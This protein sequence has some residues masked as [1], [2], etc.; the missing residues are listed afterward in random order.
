MKQKFLLLKSQDHKELIIKELAEL[1][2]G[3]FS[4]VCQEKHAADAVK[5]YL[6][7]PGRL[8]DMLRSDNMFP[9]GH[10][11]DRLI[12][13]ISELIESEEKESMELVVD[14]MDLIENSGEHVFIMEEPAEEVASLDELLDEEIEDDFIDD[15][16]VKTDD[17]IDSSIDQIS[18]DETLTDDEE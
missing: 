16:D 1:D 7:N 12:N 18:I 3:K 4:V 8:M 5:K 14:D 15:I 13:A 2:A 11:M 6:A 10:V 17:P 9:P